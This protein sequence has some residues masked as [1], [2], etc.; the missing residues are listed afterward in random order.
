[1]LPVL[2]R[3]QLQHLLLLLLLHLLPPLLQLLQQSLVFLQKIQQA[4][5]QPL[6]HPV[7]NRHRLRLRRAQNP[8]LRRQRRAPI[9]QLHQYTI[10]ISTKHCINTSSHYTRVYNKSS[11]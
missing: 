5:H 1:M 9:Q 11:F 10:H 7:L 6:P 2:S 3:Q 8:S 4:N